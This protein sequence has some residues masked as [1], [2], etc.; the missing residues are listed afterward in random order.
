MTQQAPQGQAS[1]DPCTAVVGGLS[2]NDVD[3]DDGSISR[4][5]THKEQSAHEKGSAPSRTP[6]ANPAGSETESDETGRCIDPNFVVNATFVRPSHD[7]ILSSSE[8]SGI[9]HLKGFV[10]S[11]GR[12]DSIHLEISLDDGASW[13]GVDTIEQKWHMPASTGRYKISCV[14]TIDVPITSLMNCTEVCA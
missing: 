6:A 8:S 7:E 13:T 11:S 5:P 3:S 4:T 9:F 10:Y 14:W 1:F 12:P 2:D